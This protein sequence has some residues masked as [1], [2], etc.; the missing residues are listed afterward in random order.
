MAPVFGFI[1]GTLLGVAFAWRRGGGIKDMWHY[2][3]VFGIL[4][5]LIGLFVAIFLYRAAS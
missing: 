4:F 3:A 1:F 2:S 5:A